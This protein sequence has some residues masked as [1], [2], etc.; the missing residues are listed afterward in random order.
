MLTLQIMATLPLILLCVLIN[1]L[2]QLLLKAGANK[3]GHI[4]FAWNKLF[5]L[6]LQLAT[7]PYLIAGMVCYVAS[8]FVWILV[9]SR[10]E[11]SYAYPMI[12]LGYIATAIAAY[13]LLHEPL[14]F[15]RILGIFVIITGV[16]LI[17]RS[18]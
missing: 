14:S 16:F 9:L 8:V 10:V 6:G 13:L 17:T 5:P 15:M 12:S 1:T 18:A 11:V 7:N 2:A 4:A 3:I